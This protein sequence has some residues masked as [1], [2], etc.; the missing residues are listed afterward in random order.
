M[1]AKALRAALQKANL[2]AL[3]LRSGVN[4]RTLRRIKNGDGNVM[5]AT[6]E[7]VQPHLKL[8]RR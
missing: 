7:A 1:S 8:V 2:S 4:L 6:I 3:A 5:A